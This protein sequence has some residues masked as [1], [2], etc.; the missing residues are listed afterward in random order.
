MR[1]KSRSTEKKKKKRTTKR[2]TTTTPSSE[3]KDI[4]DLGKS[5]IPRT[6]K[7]MKKKKWKAL[8]VQEKLKKRSDLREKKK[9]TPFRATLHKNKIKLDRTPAQVLQLN[10]GLYCNQACSHCHVDSTPRRKEMMSRET[11][12]H[13]LRVLRNSPSVKVLD[14]TGG[15]PELNREF[16]HLVKNA[17]SMGIE[18]IDRCNL[19]VLLEPRQEGL[20]AFL[21]DHQVHIIASLPCYLESNVDSQRGDEVFKRSIEALK[22][23]NRLGYGMGND[24]LVRCCF[25][26]L[27]N[28]L[29][30]SHTG[31]PTPTHSNTGTRSRV[32][33]N[34]CSPST[35]SVEITKRVQETSE[36][37]LWYSFRQIDL[38]HEHAH[39][40]ILRSPQQGGKVGRVH[41]Y[42]RKCVQS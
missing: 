16:R 39:Q 35:S 8:T 15:A 25:V 2:T 13:C 3:T 14:L 38:H 17:R 28:S 4:E 6:L 37:K 20:A 18:V 42:S 26:H 19:T 21:R 30:N 29:L 5:L 27:L 1:V 10:I 7:S 40:S 22:R 24:D 33:S 31:T 34:G 23:L 41:G 36:R 11:A 32:Q 9:Y 12:D